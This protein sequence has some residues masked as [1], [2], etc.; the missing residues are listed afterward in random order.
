MGLKRSNFIPYETG[1][2]LK[3]N[4]EWTE[5][6]SIHQSLFSIAFLINPELLPGTTIYL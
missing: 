2:H 1:Y 3:L 5:G 4:I 6:I